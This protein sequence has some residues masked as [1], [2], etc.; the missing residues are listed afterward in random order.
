MALQYKPTKKSV[1]RRDSVMLPIM[2]Y[3]IYINLAGTGSD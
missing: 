1:A 3:I 2:K